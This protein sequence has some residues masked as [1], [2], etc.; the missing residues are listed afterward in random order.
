MK[1]YIARSE[2]PGDT[3]HGA[4]VLLPA[5]LAIT[6]K[7]QELKEGWALLLP[8]LKNLSEIRVLCQGP[9]FLDYPPER[10]YPPE[11]KLDAARDLDD[12]LDDLEDGDVWAVMPEDFDP[13]LC[14]KGEWAELH[15]CRAYSELVAAG[16]NRDVRF[17]F[18]G[19]LK[20]VNYPACT[21]ALPDEMVN[22]AAVELIGAINK[23]GE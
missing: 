3:E 15:H 23:E 6:E 9:I 14:G 2:I 19:H 12:L 11:R 16:Y 18:I 10:C 22:P 20:Y 13:A 17:H 21:I 5:L 4:Y 7:I 8:S 1:W